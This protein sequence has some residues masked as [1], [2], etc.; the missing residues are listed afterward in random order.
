[1]LC[2]SAFQSCLP[3]HCASI[4][5]IR[6]T[7]RSDLR[8]LPYTLSRED[9]QA[10]LDA[11]KT[12]PLETQLSRSNGNTEHALVQNHVS[13]E[14]EEDAKARRRRLFASEGGSPPGEVVMSG[15]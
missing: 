14:S 9:V 2:R 1:M 10:V 12:D 15:V 4:A 7:T 5:A 3:Q 13:E 6:K 11:F 8:K